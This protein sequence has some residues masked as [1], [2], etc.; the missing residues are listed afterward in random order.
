LSVNSPYFPYIK[1]P[2]QERESRG[3]YAAMKGKNKPPETTLTACNPQSLLKLEPHLKS[4]AESKSYLNLFS[5]LPDYSPTVWAQISSVYLA[6]KKY[7]E[8]KL[9]QV[10]IDPLLSCVSVLTPIF[11]W[12]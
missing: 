1:L 3:L 9:L 6:Q 11:S 2:G 7:T 4:Q 8:V 12:L 10:H 5:H